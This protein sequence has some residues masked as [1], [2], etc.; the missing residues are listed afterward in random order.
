MIILISKFQKHKQTIENFFWR[1][2]QIFGGKAVGF[3]IFFL[4]IKLLT[5]FEFGSFKYVFSVV[6]FF[7]LFCNFGISLA[8]SIFTTQY[9][10]KKKL[11]NGY[12]NI[13]SNAFFLIFAIASI[14]SFFVIFFGKYFFYDKNIF[15]IYSIPLFFLTPVVATYD[16][17]YRGLKKF[18]SLSLISLFSGLIS[19]PFIFFFIKNYGVDGIFFS[20]VVYDIFSFILLFHFDPSKKTFKKEKISINKD[21]LKKIFSQSFFIGLASLSYLFYL[22][23]DNIILGKF[24][25]IKE[26]AHLEIV[27]FVL[28][29]IILPIPLLGNVVAPNTIKEF[30][31]NGISNY[32]RLRKHFLFF[33]TLGIFTSI[34][35]YFILP[36]VF[37]LDFFSNYKYDILIKILHLELI[38]FSM[39]FALAY[40]VNAFCTPTGYAKLLV[41]NSCIFGILNLPLDI[42]FVKH[43]GFIGVVYVT[44]ILRFLSFLFMVFTYGYII[45]KR[46]FIVDKGPSHSR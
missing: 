3:V 29:I 34:F 15:F 27:H 28:G 9:Y 45:K 36:F 18:K 17:I 35:L 11:K 13:I 30:E 42:I 20:Y 40:I 8:I 31:K 7:I 37:K 26:I 2:F 19:I 43:F 21:T 5:P 24:G 39:H 25:L 4:S 1:C 38:F 32:F 12:Q 23:T 10:I 16:G 41:I 22:K 33:L 6:S 44:L 46:F 14:F